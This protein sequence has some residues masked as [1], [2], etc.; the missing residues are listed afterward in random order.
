MYLWESG[1]G[2]KNYR[3]NNL[4]RW[5][6]GLIA[7]LVGYPEARPNFAM[8]NEIPLRLRE[9][10]ERQRER[11]EAAVAEVQALEAAAVDAAGGKPVRDALTAAQT[12]IAAIDAETVSARMRAT[13]PPRSSANWRRAMTRSFRVQCKPCREPR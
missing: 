10:A 5:L 13:R 7:G 8:L 6:D 12:R 4:V 1:F 3:A 9:H 11:A 2:T